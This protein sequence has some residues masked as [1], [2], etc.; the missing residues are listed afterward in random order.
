MPVLK[1]RERLVYFRVSEDEFRQ[2]V[3]KFPQRGLLIIISDFL[4]EQ[5]PGK[6][7]QFLTT[8]VQ[9]A[10]TRFGPAIPFFSV[11]NSLYPMRAWRDSGDNSPLCPAI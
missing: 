2:F 11:S 9:P 8:R 5:D 6:P 7:L 3:A 1:P 4:D 10:R